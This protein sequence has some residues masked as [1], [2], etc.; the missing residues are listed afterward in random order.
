MS[1]QSWFHLW[2]MSG[3]VYRRRMVPFLES[4]FGHMSPQL[5]VSHI[6]DFLITIDVIHLY[7]KYIRQLLVA[8]A[9]DVDNQ[10][11]PYCF[12]CAHFETA[13]SWIWSLERLCQHMIKDQRFTCIIY[14][15]RMG[16]KVGDD[17][18]LQG[19]HR[20][21]FPHLARNFNK[22]FKDRD[23]KNK[24]LKWHGP[25]QGESLTYIGKHSTQ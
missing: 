3:K 20:Y 14:D 9:Y 19:V 12:T 10:I 13:T 24:I 21:C 2:T 7:E 15:C 8:V 4:G 16:I 18:V 11:F 5:K 17:R 23:V 25:N 22:T 6:V 1:F